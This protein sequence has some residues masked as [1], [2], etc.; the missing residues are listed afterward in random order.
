MDSGNMVKGIIGLAIALGVLYL[1]AKV[2][3]AGW[4]S[5]KS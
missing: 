4:N 1:G 5:S 3:S 2:V